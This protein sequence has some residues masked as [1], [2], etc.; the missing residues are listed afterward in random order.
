MPVLG[1]AVPRRGSWLTRGLGKTVL[2]ALGWRF[3]VHLAD[4][5]KFV[6]IVA[7][8]TSSWDFVIGIAASLALELRTTW[9]GKHT[10]FRWPFRRFFRWLGG[11]PVDRSSR[12]G[13]VETVIDLFASR[14]AMIFGLSPEGTRKKVDTWKTGFYHIAHGAGVPI[15][16]AY[17]DYERRIIGTGKILHPSGDLESDIEIL[18]SVYKGVVARD[19][20]RA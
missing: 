7:P 18:R 2:S 12:Q 6:V 13:V 14:E 10:L 20:T 15:V 9:I 5:P 8:H 3:E 4:I 16:P 19:P 11:I 1:D 17:L